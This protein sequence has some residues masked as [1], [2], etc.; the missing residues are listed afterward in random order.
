MKYQ[1]VIRGREA[2]GFTRL[3]MVMVL[4]AIAVLLGG[5]IHLIGTVTKR[6]MLERAEQAQIQWVERDFLSIGMALKAYKINAGSYPS[7]AQG[8]AALVGK[9]S[10]Q[11]QP[12]NWVQVM[13]KLPTD[14]W[15]NE[16]GYVFPGRKDPSEFEIISRGK[17]GNEGGEQDY[18]SQDA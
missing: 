4:G 8:L 3:K 10:D 5:S 18:S 1:N 14:P 6:V 17:D 9:P 13:K 15:D 2:S 7:T 12:T 11:P 16:Y